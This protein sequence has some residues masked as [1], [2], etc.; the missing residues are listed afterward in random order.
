MQLFC[1]M[2]SPAQQSFHA[3]A[4]AGTLRKGSA[5]PQSRG[6]QP[7]QPYPP[8]ARA[9]NR[10]TSNATHARL[11]SKVLGRRSPKSA[12]AGIVAGFPGLHIAQRPRVPHQSFPE[13][14]PP[15][16]QHPLD[17]PT[18]IQHNSTDEH[19]G[20]QNTNV[21]RTS[22]SKSECKPAWSL[23]NCGWMF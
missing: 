16:P 5:A 20:E 15:L 1:E 19:R 23:R 21:G 2:C 7:H 13:R 10:R 11:V 8:S 3:Q 6:T 4:D 18:W 17:A 9:S 12:I 22:A 14:S